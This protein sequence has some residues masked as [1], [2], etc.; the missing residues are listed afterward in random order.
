MYPTSKFEIQ[1]ALQLKLRMASPQVEQLEKCVQKKLFVKM[2]TY[3]KV[4]FVLCTSKGW[5]KSRKY[6]PINMVVSFDRHNS[7]DN[8]RGSSRFIN[9]GEKAVC[10]LV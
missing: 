5:V 1:I 10:R 9:F 2:S 4:N 7:S 8:A 6:L 3:R